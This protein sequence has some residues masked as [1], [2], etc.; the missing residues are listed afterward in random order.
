MAEESE[1]RKAVRAGAARR[2]ARQLS[3]AEE[4]E[5][6]CVEA[7]KARLREEYL[8]AQARTR[9]AAEA[10][11]REAAELQAREK[12]EARARQAARLDKQ[13]APK[14]SRPAR[15]LD[16]QA[17]PQRRIATDVL[18]QTQVTRALTEGERIS[19]VE[20]R[21]MERERQA[22]RADS[23]R[24]VSIPTKPA[25]PAKAVAPAR[26]ATPAQSAPV[27]SA[28]ILNEPAPAQP[29]P[30]SSASTLNEPAP[31]HHSHHR[32]EAA[33][34]PD[35]FED[36]E[37]LR[38]ARTESS[39]K[40]ASPVSDE[41][42]AGVDDS[43]DARPKVARDL[44]PTAPS[45]EEFDHL[46][47]R[48][49]VV[50]KNIR[51]P[52][53]ANRG[54]SRPSGRSGRK[55]L[56]QGMTVSALAVGGIAVPLLGGGHLGGGSAQASEPLTASIVGGSQRL[57]ATPEALAGNPNAVIRSEAVAAGEQAGDNSGAQC[58]PEGA[59]GTR[60]AFVDENSSQVVFPLDGGTYHRSSPFGLRQD[61]FGG[62]SSYHAGQ[63]Y[64]A[65][66]DTPIY[67]IA[68]GTVT[69]A[70][71]SAE[72]RSPNTIVVEHEIDGKK[73]ESWYVHMWD[74]GVMVNV[75][76]KVSAGEQIGKVGSNGNST[77]PHL[78]LEIHDPSLG[79]GD[80]IAP[81]MDPESFLADHEA[82][83]VS[84]LCD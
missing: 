77:G 59:Q 72:G 18:S 45:A 31:A 35:V 32:V 78:H 1:R 40:V 37:A 13:S 70:G 74:H 52:K 10:R 54:S 80:S 36:F 50:E 24:S 48:S 79:G 17:T 82:I 6:Q 7:D 57:A 38:A 8:A 25:A 81:L 12:N 55:N 58:T 83:D 9:Q 3:L 63:D 62:G 41:V 47:G 67:A 71:G 64:A 21:R 26:P 11:A 33:P 69:F 23:A 60:A 44:I 56:L 5:C 19:R 27:S 30:A 65:P 76:D 61:P 34:S 39:A 75:G 20:R 84:Q 51:K 22:A 28:S 66:N 15:Q 68:D 4:E 16:G 2:R 29:T 42:D 43:I 53:P 73:Y 46:I 49:V 14:D